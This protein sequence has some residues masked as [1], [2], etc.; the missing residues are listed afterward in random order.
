MMPDTKKHL[1]LVG[2]IIC[3]PGGRPGHRYRGALGKHLSWWP[4]GKAAEG[5]SLAWCGLLV[6]LQL[7]FPEEGSALKTFHPVL[8]QKP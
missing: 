5:L 4:T 1:W 2:S 6:C 7:S 3:F 8:L